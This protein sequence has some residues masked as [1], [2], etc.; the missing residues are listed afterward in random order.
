M[1]STAHKVLGYIKPTSVFKTITEWEDLAEELIALQAKGFDTRA[2]EISCKYA[3]YCDK[4]DFDRFVS[5]INEFF[6]YLLGIEVE[7]YELLTRKNVLDFIEDFINHRLWGLENEFD[8]YFPDIRSLRF[9]YFY[10]RGDIEPYVLLDEA[11]TS[12]TYGS[13]WNPK[14]LT[15][16]ATP[17]GLANLQR[18]L[19]DGDTFDI[20]CFTVAKRPFF[21]A[22]S[23]LLIRLIGN[24]RAGFHSDIKSLATDS[25]RRAC[26]L[27]RLEYPGKDINN[28]CYELDS[29]NGEVRTSLWNEYIA[30]PLEIL[31]VQKV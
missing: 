23:N 29:C 26:N 9:A 10:S 12:Q 22:Q 21:R 15:H 27:Y 17:N 16:Y 20:S 19:Q 24:V 7:R 30:T 6:G 8:H 18:A 5:L 14:E 25:G 4:N 3:T 31:E 13:A 2:G 1:Q 11:Y 28:I